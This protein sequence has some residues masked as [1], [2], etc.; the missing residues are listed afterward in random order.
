MQ[1]RT[2]NSPGRT[3]GKALTGIRVVRADGTAPTARVVLIRT[4]ALPL[5]LLVFGVGFLMIPVRRDHRALHDL[6]AGTAVV[7]DWG[8]RPAEMPG[9]LADF[10]NRIQSAPDRAGP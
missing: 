3:I 2:T 5:S 9:P 4:L 10:L 7:Y 6:I 8:D 1:R